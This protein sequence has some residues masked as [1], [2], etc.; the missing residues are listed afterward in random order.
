MIGKAPARMARVGLVNQLPLNRVAARFLD[1]QPLETELAV[2]TL[3]SGDWR[4]G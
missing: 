4:T 3:I 2:L 1:G